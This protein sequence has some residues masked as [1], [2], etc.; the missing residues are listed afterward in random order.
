MSLAAVCLALAGPAR[1]GSVPDGLAES[2]RGIQH[3]WAFAMYRVD[4][5][6]KEPAFEAL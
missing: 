2:L 3:D 6:E 4:D 1:G 5:D